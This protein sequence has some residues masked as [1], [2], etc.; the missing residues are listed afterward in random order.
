MAD[1]S[2]ASKAAMASA[3]QDAWY[4][5]PDPSKLQDFI[6]AGIAMGRPDLKICP[7][8]MSRKLEGPIVADPGTA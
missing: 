5:I 4:L 6:A 2:D 8:H 1:I 3:P 7:A